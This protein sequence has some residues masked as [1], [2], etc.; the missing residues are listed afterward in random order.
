M[1]KQIKI[2]KIYHDNIFLF[3]KIFRYNKKLFFV[4]LGYAILTSISSLATVLLPKY[5]LEAIM[6]ENFQN[7]VHVLALYFTIAIFIKLLSLCYENY[8]KGASERMYLQIINEFLRKGIELDLSFFDKSESYSKYNR[9]FGNCCDV[10]ERCNNTILSVMTSLIQIFMLGSILIGIN[11]YIFIVI[12]A[13]IFI[14]ILINNALKKCSHEFRVLLSEKNKQVNYFYRLFYTP[15]FIK[16]IKASSIEKFIFD[17]KQHVNKDILDLS[18]KEI[19]ATSKYKILLNAI[20]LIEYVSAASYFA[21]MVIIKLIS[22]SSYFTSLNAYQQIKNSI[23]SL[24]SAY[25]AFY[26]N[27]LF[28]DDYIDFMKSSENTTTNTNGILLNSN[29]IKTITFSNV[30]FK[31][32][33]ANS[34]ALNN[35][36]FSVNK[37]DRIAIVGKNGAGKTTLIKLLLRLYD[38]DRGEIAINGINIKEYDTHSLRSSIVTLFQDYVIYA[39][40]VYDNIVLGRNIS[41]ESVEKALADVGM[42]EKVNALNQGINTPISSQLYSGGIEFSG[43]EAQ[44]IAISRVFCSALP[45][46]VLDEP[47]SSLDPYSEYKLYSQLLDSSNKDK[48]FMVVSHRLTFTHKMSNILVLENGIITESGTH[49]ELMRKNGTYAEMYKLQAEKFN[50]I[51]T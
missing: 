43:G 22:I 29:S 34:Y 47:T 16:D 30:T 33:N 3:K 10:I 6:S 49:E 18:Q 25:T 31:Y 50:G 44:K 12:I 37:G 41:S 27:S 45:V 9:A 14:N 23:S 42:L 36:S 24:L 1:K 8:N 2:S 17:K 48:T 21:Y 46:F 7:T 35:V 11:V 15:N 4:R 13:F 38:P 26:D 20:E 39:F 32:P 40:S 19:K 28:A 5:L 51:E